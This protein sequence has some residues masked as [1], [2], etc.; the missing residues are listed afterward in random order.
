MRVEAI[1]TRESE[2]TGKKADETAIM[3]DD[4]GSEIVVGD[5]ARDSAQSGEGVNVTAGEGPEA[6]T[7]GELDIQ[8]PAVSI[9][10]R[11]RVQLA[12]VA[13]VAERAEV[14]PVHLESFAGQRFHADEGPFGRDVRARVTHVFPQNAVTALISSGA[15]L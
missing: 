7:V 1:I 8:H 10:Q 6:L 2:E 5:L 3:F 15:E 4:R 13:R 12:H 9:D 14:A 11:E